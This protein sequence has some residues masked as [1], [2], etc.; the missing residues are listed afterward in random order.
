MTAFDPSTAS[1]SPSRTEHVPEMDP[2]ITSIQPGGGPVM[3]LELAWGG[4]RRWYLK[5][6]RKNY[7]ARMQVQRRGTHNQTPHEVLD[8]RDLKYYQ[9]QPGYYWHEEDDPFAWRDELPFARVGLAELLLF[10]TV[11]FGIAGLLAWWVTTASL[12]PVGTVSAWFG[13][14]A[15]TVCGLLVLWFFRDPRR[16][17]PDEPGVVVSPADGK[18]VTLRELE[19]CEELGGIP[20]IQVGI[21]LSIFNCHLNRSPK[22]SRV[23]RLE[24]RRGKFLN[25]LKPESA[26]EN[27]TLT[28][29]LE[30]TDGPPRPFVV[31]QITGLIA[32]R[33]VCWLKPGDE[34]T[35]GERVGMIKFGSRT[36]LLLPSEGF[37]LKATLGQKI[38]AGTDVVG[39]FDDAAAES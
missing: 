39:H 26:K 30:T 3:R 25:A 16:T 21:F 13:V 24:Y 15:A 22:A 9:N 14:A 34:L 35:T 31:K 37:T 12:G 11:F 5:T 2:Q 1:E 8:P 6:F 18:I 33:I 27:E 19:A 7:V 10:T 20:A 28:I 17:V 36:E 23:T 29:H 38:K 4:V 32:R